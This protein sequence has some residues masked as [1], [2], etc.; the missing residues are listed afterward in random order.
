MANDFVS[1]R[2]LI[3]SL[4]LCGAQG[5]GCDG[6]A[7]SELLHSDGDCRCGDKLVL[8]AAE[9]LEEYVDRCARY[10]ET[11]AAQHEAE[12]GQSV[13]VPRGGEPA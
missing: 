11:L 2:D 9:R 6:C 8:L 10:A 12:G 1:T 3:A 5:V 4:R 7:F 13:M